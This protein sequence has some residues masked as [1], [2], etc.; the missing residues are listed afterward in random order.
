MGEAIAR[1]LV[2]SLAES[3]RNVL[4]AVV[5]EVG[6]TAIGCGDVETFAAECGRGRCL[7]LIEAIAGND[8]VR[9][10]LDHTAVDVSFSGRVALLHGAAAQPLALHPAVDY[11]VAAPCSGDELRDFV[12]GCL[13]DTGHTKTASGQRTR[14]IPGRI[15]YTPSAGLR[16]RRS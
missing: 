13:G 7:V 2:V 1:V 4:V 15:S 3:I 16:R 9:A 12:R 11:V 10:A 6:A 14:A 8:L 5:E